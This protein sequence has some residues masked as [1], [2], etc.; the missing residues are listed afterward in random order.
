VLLTSGGVVKI[1]DFGVSTAIEGTS[2]QHQTVIG[3]PQW[4]A[5]EVRFK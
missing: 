2:G 5:P 3:T 4:M 1:G